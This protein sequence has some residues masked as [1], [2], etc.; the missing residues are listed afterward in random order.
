MYV[1]GTRKGEKKPLYCSEKDA[2]RALHRCLEI[3]QDALL[4][5]VYLYVRVCKYM[6]VSVCLCM[7]KECESKGTRLP[8]SLE[9]RYS[10]RQTRSQNAK[11]FPILSQAPSI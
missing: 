9:V 3:L 8:I 10:L 1:I 11:P 7:Y 4:Q 5:H 6:C 2:H